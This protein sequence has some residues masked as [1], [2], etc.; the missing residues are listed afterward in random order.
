VKEEYTYVDDDG[1]SIRVSFET[2]MKSGQILKRSGKFYR[3]VHDPATKKSKP[4]AMRT[5]IL[6]DNLGFGHKSLA[7]MQKH[8][9]ESKV[10]GVEFVQDRKV[11]EFFQVRCDGPRS[12]NA[13]LKARGM[14]D[15]N[16]RNGSGGLSERDFQNARELVDPKNR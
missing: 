14:F 13:Y 4:I 5:E 9:S 15:R 11:P 7:K 1:N 3:R 16:S 12:F 8:L 2:M 6:S 10:K